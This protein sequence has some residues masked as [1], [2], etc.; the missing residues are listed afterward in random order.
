MPDPFD[1]T[2]YKTSFTTTGSYRPQTFAFA[3]FPHIFTML[4]E[5]I[6]MRQ[7]AIQLC[8]GVPASLFINVEL[9]DISTPAGITAAIELFQDAMRQFAEGDLIDSYGKMPGCP[10]Y[11]GF[12]SFVIN[13]LPI[14]GMENVMPDGD[15]TSPP[16]PAVVTNRLDFARE[17]GTNINEIILSLNALQF[18]HGPMFFE[19]PFDDSCTIYIDSSTG[20]SENS[21]IGNN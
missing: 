14:L 15:F 12:F 6:K 13:G 5:Q 16:D 11:I 3:N 18:I 10:I 20:S 4:T 8:F 21:S 1:I 9:Y 17:V 7:A 19:Y 2:Q